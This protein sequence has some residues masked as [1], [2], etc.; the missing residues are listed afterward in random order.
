MEDLG[1]GRKRASWCNKV[2]APL[3]QGL[4]FSAETVNNRFMIPGV[5]GRG[6]EVAGEGIMLIDSHI[7]SQL[8][9][10]VAP[11]SI[12]PLL[13][14]RL[15]HTISQRNA[16]VVAAVVPLGCQLIWIWYL[17]PKANDD[18]LSVIK[19]VRKVSWPRVRVPKLGQDPATASRNET[20][21][22]INGLH[23]QLPKKKT[24]KKWKKKQKTLKV[25]PRSKTVTLEGFACEKNTF[26]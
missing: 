3:F 17:W 8:R 21:K 13:G 25:D 20:S 10:R 5:W 9:L 2:V 19:N 14:G 15:V 11:R 23:L 7:I 22:K 12:P 16:K 1:L 4:Q 24:N 18:C 6:R 26:I